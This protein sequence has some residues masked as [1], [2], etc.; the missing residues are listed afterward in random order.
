VKRRA[1]IDKGVGET[2]IVVFE[3]RK[4]V[5]FYLERAWETDRPKTGDMF[6]GR[7]ISVDRNLGG[8]FVDLGAPHTGFLKLPASPDAP[9]LTGG[10]AVCVSVTREGFRGKAAVLDYVGIG[11]GDMNG[12]ISRTR[13]EDRLKARFKDD[14]IFDYAAVTHLYEACEPVIAL[15]GGGDM[16]I[17]QTRAL[18]AI[19][20]D[21]GTA[22]NGFDAAKAAAELIPAQLRLRGMG[23]LIVVDFPNLW[24]KKH[25][26]QIIETLQNGFKTDPHIVKIAP[27]SR[28]GTVEL[29]RQKPMPSL[30]ERI[31]DK[32]GALSIPSQSMMALQMLERAGR[33][34]PGARLILSVPE[35]VRD[36]LDSGL[37][38]WRHEMSKR[39]GR[40][41]S[42]ETGYHMDVKADR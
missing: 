19:D 41:F 27:M 6:Q 12:L 20:V 37:V 33:T 29:T 34:S 14:I 3:G 39:L 18:L 24:Q 22:R 36:W 8:A 4:P 38:D 17:E 25:R 26:E 23:G 28:F 30:D 2:R 1:V 11:K 10:Q 42:L 13:I 9:K 35:T 7:I 16:A 40:R 15:P 32:S 5:E 31:L 21:R